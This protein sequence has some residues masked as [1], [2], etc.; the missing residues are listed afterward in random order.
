MALVNQAVRKFETNYAHTDAK[1]HNNLMAVTG[2][3][4]IKGMF[5]HEESAVDFASAVDGV[6]ETKAV[7]VVGVALGDIVTGVSISVDLVD[8][9]LT[10]YV[11]AADTVD[12]RLQ[13]ESTATVN[14]ASATVRLIIADM[15]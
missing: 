15:T 6:G 10:A 11:S 13:N 1:E 2:N 4:L 3:N 5:V 8:M 9:V 7:T 12:V 14:L